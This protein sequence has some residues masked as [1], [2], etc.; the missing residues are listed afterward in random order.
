MSIKTKP[1]TQGVINKTNKIIFQSYEK[2]INKRMKAGKDV[3][4]LTQRLN[5]LVTEAKK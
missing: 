5:K 1:I 2:V 3:T 4:Q